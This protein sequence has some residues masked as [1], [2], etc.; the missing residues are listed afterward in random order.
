MAATCEAYD[1]LVVGGGPAGMAAAASAAAAGLSTA[2]VDERITLGGQIYK[3]MGPGF[4]VSDPKALGRDYERGQRLIDSVAAAGVKVMTA[5]SVVSIEATDAVLVEDGAPARTVAARAIVL[6]PGAR[7]RAVAFPGWTL[8]GVLTAGGAQTMVKTQRVLP[9]RRLVFAGSG[10][11]A[12][13]FP[14]QLH[15]LGAGVQLVLEAGPPP[16][17]RD[18]AGMALAS[19]G[20]LDLLADAVRYRSQLL[21]ARVPLRYRRIVLAAEGEGRVESVTH[22]AA[23]S[24]WRPIAGTEE[25]VDADV[26]CL[27]YGFTPSTELLRLAGCALTHDEQRGGAVAVL[28][29]WMRTSVKGVL[30]AGDGTGVEGVHVAVEEGRLAGL[31]AAL[32]LG[33]MQLS[34]ALAQAAPIR[35]MLRRRRAFRRALS[36]MHRVGPGIYGLARQDTVVCRCEAVAR[37]Q[38]DEAIEASGDIGVVKGLTRAGMGLCQA[39][40]CEGQIRAMI[41]HRHGVSMGEVGLA[42]ARAPVR[43]VALGAIADQSVE[44]R[45]LF[46]GGES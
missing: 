27:G 44:D 32:D 42:T 19:P 24:R 39:R 23:D 7:D 11:L 18:L 17:A 28:D 14:A 40:S 25:R 36:R 2:I 1:V 20:N 43:P 9:G 30:S 13:A 10:P 4:Q 37:G 33:A 45:G 6:A 8:P 29:E 41:A 26:L 34:D 22:A 16:R 31:G 3:R 21:R 12:L 5:T 38:L 46:V 15:H 35:R